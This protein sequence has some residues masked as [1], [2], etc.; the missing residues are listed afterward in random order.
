MQLPDNIRQWFHDRGITDES[1]DHFN[2]GWTGS[3]IKIPIYDSFKLRRSPFVSDGPKY[4]NPKGS[5]TVLFK[6]DNVLI[7]HSPV[8]VLEGELDVIR[9]HSAGFQAVCST[10]GAGTFKKEWLSD[11]DNP[12]VFVCY[13]YD[14]AGISGAF[15]VLDTVYYAKIVWL[16]KYVGEHGDFTDFFRLTEN[17]PEE[18]GSLCNYSK[19][20]SLPHFIVN[21]EWSKNDK[22]RLYTEYVYK[23]MEAARKIR[24][25]SGRDSRSDAPEQYLISLYMNE[26][27]KLKKKPSQRDNYDNSTLANAKNVPITNFLQFNSDNTSRCIFHADRSPSMHYY[28]SNN[29]VYCFGCKKS[30]DVLDVIQHLNG[31][32][33]PEAVTIALNSR[34]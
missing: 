11:L 28:E 19:N 6:S 10:G 18:F 9:A 27:E 4:L 25:L 2:I 12:D 33:L 23:I 3:H 24:C 34:G 15:N 14:S 30:A 31:C 7:P 26:I 8:L 17:A 16:P 29:R 5:P 22:I 32:T 13:D 20:Y 1:L 21:P